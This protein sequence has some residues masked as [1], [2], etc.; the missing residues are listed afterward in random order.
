VE[1]ADEENSVSIDADPNRTP[2]KA[3]FQ[4]LAMDTGN[5]S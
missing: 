5:K 1:E 2:A 4:P 3:R